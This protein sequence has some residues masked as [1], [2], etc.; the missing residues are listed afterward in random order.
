MNIN[1]IYKIS[2]LF[3]KKASSYDDDSDYEEDEWIPRVHKNLHEKCM[4]PSFDDFWAVV[5]PENKEFI[6]NKLDVWDL[7]PEV[8][9]EQ[10]DKKWYSI[11]FDQSIP[12]EERE[13]LQNEIF[14]N[15][16]HYIISREE[17]IRRNSDHKCHGCC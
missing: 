9:Q 3:F 10:L 13:R 7:T 2:N 15:I 14:K 5:S 6:L 17:W 1:K 11:L 12:I 16:K 4:I 8:T